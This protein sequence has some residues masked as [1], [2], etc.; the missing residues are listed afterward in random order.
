MEKWTLMYFSIDE[1]TYPILTSRVQWIE[2]GKV[3]N[4][5]DGNKMI[6]GEVLGTR[7]TKGELIEFDLEWQKKKA[8]QTNENSTLVKSTS[9]K[10]TTKTKSKH[11][12]EPSKSKKVAKVSTSKQC[13]ALS[14]K[15]VEPSNSK[16][17]AKPPKTTTKVTEPT[18]LT[19]KKVTKSS[20]SKQATEPP[21]SKKI[22]VEPAKSK[23]ETSTTNKSKS[24]LVMDGKPKSKSKAAKS[25]RA[26]DSVK[27]SSGPEPDR[28]MSQGEKDVVKAFHHRQSSK[29]EKFNGFLVEKV[30]LSK[31]K[32][33]K[34]KDPRNFLEKPKR[35]SS[36]P[37]LSPSPLPLVSESGL[38]RSLSPWSPSKIPSLS[39]SPS[40]LRSL[41]S[42]SSLTLSSLLSSSCT[43]SSL[44]SHPRSPKAKLLE[45]PS[46]VDRLSPLS[47]TANSP[48]FG[49]ELSNV[50]FTTPAA[51]SPRQLKSRKSPIANNQAVAVQTS[52]TVDSIIQ[53]NGTPD[54]SRLFGSTQSTPFNHKNMQIEDLRRDITEWKEQMS[55]QLTEIK[56]LLTNLTSP[57]RK[58][59]NEGVIDVTQMDKYIHTD[60]FAQSFLAQLQPELLSGSLNQQHQQG[61]S[62]HHQQQSLNHHQQQP[63]PHNN[64]QQR[65]SYLQQDYSNQLP[66]SNQSSQESDINH[67]VSKSEKKDMI[68]LASDHGLVLI[69]AKF[70]IREIL[71]CNINGRQKFKPFDHRVISCILNEVNSKYRV[72]EYLEEDVQKG[73]TAKL[74]RFRQSLREKLTKENKLHEFLE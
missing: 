42:S 39:R 17:V 33:V 8:E 3:G 27:D 6:R 71:T 45:T 24:K 74:K 53:R 11:V 9:P 31:K 7:R 20:H 10:S 25:E 36:S 28:K 2:K 32:K 22:V 55:N 41:S 47:S 34:A 56:C 67:T 46:T 43:S 26:K 70:S 49:Q 40:R 35:K 15:V 68:K 44:P 65:A 29:M 64:Q 12:A 60:N 66:S 48:S 59:S 16:Q 73:I 5:L 1:S 13:G 37:S 57:P 51:K 61:A 4:V 69:K 38:R 52:P 23:Q 18:K 63:S 58:D 21:K 30:V 19:K 14:K 50:S 72:P 62:N 54:F